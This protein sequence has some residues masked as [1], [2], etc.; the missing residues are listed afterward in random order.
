MF[1][2]QKNLQDLQRK[3]DK[4][5]VLNLL[6]KILLAFKSLFRELEETMS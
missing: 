4:A 3:W 1:S 2:S 5:Q 6:S